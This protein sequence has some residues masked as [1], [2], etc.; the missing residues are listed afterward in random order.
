[1]SKE[2]FHAR[3][4]ATFPCPADAAQAFPWDKWQSCLGLRVARA[5][6]PQALSA[7]VSRPR[8]VAAETV[9]TDTARREA[10]R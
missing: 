1:M 9:A 5:C 2:R 10:S 3:V 7:E 6:K 8:Q 4:M